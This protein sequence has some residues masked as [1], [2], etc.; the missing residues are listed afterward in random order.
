[1]RNPEDQRHLIAQAV[2]HVRSQRAT[3][4]RELADLMR[5]SPTT[6]GQYASICSAAELLDG[7]GADTAGENIE[8]LNEIIECYG[9]FSFIIPVNNFNDYVVDK[10]HSALGDFIKNK[11]AGIWP[12]TFID[13]DLDSAVEAAK[14]AIVDAEIYLDDEDWFVVSE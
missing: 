5:L 8:Q 6:A 11:E 2:L 12:Y 14:E 13:I 3:S 4:R 7:S 9:S 1:M 10:V